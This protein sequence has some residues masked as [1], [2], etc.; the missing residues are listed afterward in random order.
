L[1]L[2]VR[3]TAAA[4]VEG[5]AVIRVF[6]IDDTPQMRTMLEEMLA[7]EDFE[8]V[9]STA[10][11]AEALKEM[12]AADPHVVVLDYKMPGLDGIMT[13]KLIREERPDQAIILYTAYLDDIL[14]RKA[15]KAGI[16]LCVGKLEGI[17]TLEHDIRRLAG[18]VT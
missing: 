17:L 15:A 11:G 12:E 1:G 13:A 5:V 10:Y 3:P 2:Q 4:R 9:G 16:A 7:L 14:E 8:V 6:L 18:D